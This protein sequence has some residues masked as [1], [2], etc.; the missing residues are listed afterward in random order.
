MLVR[1]RK[2]RLMLQPKR[3][4]ALPQVPA[5]QIVVLG[6]AHRSLELVGPRHLADELVGA[7]QGAVVHVDVV[8]ADHSVLPELGVVRE[9]RAAVQ[10]KAQREMGVVIQVG[11]GGHD[12][13]H[14]SSL[15]QRD[16]RGHPQAGRRERSRDTHSDGGVVRQH[17]L[18]EEMAG[19]P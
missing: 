4:L 19:L 17:S 16:H 11:A 8:D 5:E 6:A 1:H 12:P 18:G 13:V 2:Q 14:E 7:E 9:R 10:G 15:Y 3:L